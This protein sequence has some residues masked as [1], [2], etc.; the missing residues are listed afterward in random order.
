MTDLTD[1]PYKEYRGL[2]FVPY[3]T[4]FKLDGPDSS[5]VKCVACGTLFSLSDLLEGKLKEYQCPTCHKHTLKYWGNI[6]HRA[7]PK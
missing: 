2:P 5:T 1:Y 6:P 4:M 7:V 3:A